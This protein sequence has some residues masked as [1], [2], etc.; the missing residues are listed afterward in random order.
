M[1][2]FAP[3]GP[4]FE[5]VVWIGGPGDVD[6]LGWEEGGGQV[7]AGYVLEGIE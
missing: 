5:G 4:L 2:K 7:E 3:S 1:N 6:K